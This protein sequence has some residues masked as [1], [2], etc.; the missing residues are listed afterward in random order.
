MLANRGGNPAAMDVDRQAVVESRHRQSG[1]AFAQPRGGGIYLGAQLLQ[2]AIHR[3]ALARALAQ[4]AQAANEQRAVAA[5]AVGQ[6]R[7]Q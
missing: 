6:P 3:F 2:T 4:T 1:A 5:R 7:L